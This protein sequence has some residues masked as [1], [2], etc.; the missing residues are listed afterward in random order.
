MNNTNNIA[1]QPSLKPMYLYHNPMFMIT[2][3]VVIVCENGVV[4]ILDGMEKI[5]HKLTTVAYD[6]YKF[7]GGQVKAGQ[8]TIPFAAVRL[9][10]EQTGIILKKTDLI[11]VDFRSEPE[12]SSGGNLVDIG[13]VA[14]VDDVNGLLHN[15]KLI[16]VNFETQELDVSTS[17]IYMDHN[18]LLQRALDVMLI[19]K[20]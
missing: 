1:L 15:S 17:K 19:M 4:M 11:P 18:I 7:P 16:P 13:M 20:D 12:R 2:V 14:M 8:E 6:V 3:S 10:K 9:V 5:K